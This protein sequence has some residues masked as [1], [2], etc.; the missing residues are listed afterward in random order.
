MIGSKNSNAR[1]LIG[2]CYCR[3][4]RFEVADEF[5]YAMNCH[6]SNCRR[7]TGAAFKPFAG[8]PHD[9]LRIVRGGDLRMIFGDETTHNAHCAHCGS[10][11]Y[12]RV[13]EGEWVHVAMGTLVDAPS[14]RPSAHIFVGSKA[15][16]YDIT[17]NLPQ[18]REHIGVV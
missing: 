13:R 18:Y 4:V 6:C 2:E 8:I 11:L 14:I 17:D 7:T 9:K 12:S 3:A 16:W 10:L 15:P 5:S 1:I